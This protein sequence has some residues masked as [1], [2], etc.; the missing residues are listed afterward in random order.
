MSARPLVARLVTA[1]IAP[2]MKQHGFKR[3]ALTFERKH[4]AVLQIVNVQCS[5]GGDSFYVNVGVVLDEVKALRASE[6]GSQVF[7][8]HTVHFG[9][10]L[11]SLAP[12]L[13]QSWKAD[14]ANAGAE[15]AAGLEKALR[16]LNAI[17]SAAAMLAEVDL[18]HGFHK[19]L[20][21]QLVWIGGDPRGARADLEA[22]AKE[23]SDRQGCS[24]EQLAKRAG[25]RGL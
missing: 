7:G 3:K 9:S 21:A 18:R 12:A 16:K 2:L 24:V 11:D 8:G 22:V 5:H 10:R 15:V 17:D 20:R 4:G 14:D 1:S 6:T 13:P 23:F 25:L 19:V